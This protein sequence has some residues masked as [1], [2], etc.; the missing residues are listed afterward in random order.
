M[1]NA[2]LCEALW[3]PYRQR[4]SNLSA[5]P[6]SQ[7]TA[8]RSPERICHRRLIRIWFSRIRFNRSRYRHR[9]KG[10]EPL[11][12]PRAA[13]PTPALRANA[14]NHASHLVVSLPQ[15]WR[16]SPRQVQLAGA[17]QGG[18]CCYQLPAKRVLTAAHSLHSVRRLSTLPRAWPAFRLR[19]GVH[20]PRH[21]LHK[22]ACSLALLFWRIQ[23]E[24]DQ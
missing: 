22:A 10:A 6:C 17:H 2:F 8:F 5:T 7:T 20:W 23:T 14:Q 3:C 1:A 4:T 19:L 11:R 18:Q 12:G 9:C 24:A 15:A 13:T 21:D 16:C